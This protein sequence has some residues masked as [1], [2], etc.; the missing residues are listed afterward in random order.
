M[1]TS[2]CSYHSNIKFISSRYRVI[3]SISEIS[4][5][6]GLLKIRH[7]HRFVAVVIQFN[8]KRYMFAEHHGVAPHVLELRIR[9]FQVIFLSRVRACLQGG[10]VTLASGLTLAGGQKIAPVYK[11]NFTGR[12]TLHPG[13]T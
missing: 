6:P 3:S 8:S 7:S 11:Q 4:T 2:N 13:T 5:D 1:K 12:V 9:G 10:R